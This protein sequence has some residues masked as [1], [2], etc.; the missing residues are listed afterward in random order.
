MDSEGWDARYAANNLVWGG[1]PNQFVVREF[2]G[3]IPGSALDLGAGEGR[4]SLWLAS[5]GWRVTAVDFSEVAIESG[6]RLAAA[7]GVEIDWVVA[8]VRDYCPT[9][10][11]FDAVLVAYLHLPAADLT[12][13]LGHAAQAVS[14]GGRLVIIGHD[15]A[16]LTEGTGGPQ[17]AAILYTPEKIVSDLPGLRVERAERVTRSV[18]TEQGP[19]T[20]IDTL[21][22]AIRPSVS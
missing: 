22:R 2:E 14:P 21:V 8:D 3:L 20:A 9:E 12:Q 19:Q 4:N 10:T 13:A 16:N 1:A 5:R 7:R 15:V 6:A 11:G 17:D 18:T